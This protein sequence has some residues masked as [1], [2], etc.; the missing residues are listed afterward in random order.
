MNV[1]VPVIHSDILLFIGYLS[2]LFCFSILFI[3]SLSFIALCRIAIFIRGQ[4]VIWRSL[5]F[6]VKIIIQYM[7]HINFMRIKFQ[8]FDQLDWLIVFF[9]SFFVS[10]FHINRSAIKMLK[11]LIECQMAGLNVFSNKKTKKKNEL[12]QKVQMKFHSY[13][14][15]VYFSQVSTLRD[16]QKFI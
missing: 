5:Y 14:S 6:L 10:F 8:W 9:L 11:K 3:L 1:P 4:L 16:G 7:L 13:C 15:L 2:T 12:K